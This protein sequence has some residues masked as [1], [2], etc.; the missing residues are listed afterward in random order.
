MTDR[1]MADNK[2]TSKGQEIK[3][4]IRAQTIGYILAAFSLVAGLAWNE[5]I[6]SMIDNLFPVSKNSLLVK[7]IYA[8]VVTGAVVVI[9]SYLVRLTNNKD[10]K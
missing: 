5:A 3:K 9:S 10:E 6:R 2:P 4:Q 8:V 1:E 7:F